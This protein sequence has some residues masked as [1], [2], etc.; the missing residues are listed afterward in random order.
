MKWPN[1]EIIM[2]K[3][4][5]SHSEL[6]V[7]SCYKWGRVIL[8]VALYENSIM[9]FSCYTRGHV[10]LGVALFW[11]LYGMFPNAKIFPEKFRLR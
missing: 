9:I 3:F 1:Y 2:N 10:I 4:I 7:K 6:P 5:V 8:E 11:G